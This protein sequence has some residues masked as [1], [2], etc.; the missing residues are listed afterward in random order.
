MW[1]TST[2]LDA[3][4]FDAIRA[5]E[6][7]ARRHRSLAGLLPCLAQCLLCA[8]GLLLKAV[9]QCCV[10]SGSVC[11]EAGRDTRTSPATAKQSHTDRRVSLA[12][13]YQFG[14][15]DRERSRGA[16]QSAA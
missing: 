3:S 14:A 11:R 16:E 10:L 15:N 12:P 5:V 13:T 7:V 2:S 8:L 4:S 6:Q 9:R 1:T